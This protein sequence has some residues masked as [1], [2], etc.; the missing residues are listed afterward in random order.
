MKVTLFQCTNVNE[1]KETS[2]LPYPKFSSE[3]NSCDDLVKSVYCV[4]KHNGSLGLREGA[5]YVHLQ[6]VSIEHEIF[7]EKIMVKYKWTNMNKTKSVYSRSGRPGY[8][9]GKP[10]ITGTK[11]SN[12]ILMSNQ[13]EDWLTLPTAQEKGLCSN[14]SRTNLMFNVNTRTHCKLRFPRVSPISQQFCASLQDQVFYYD[15]FFLQAFI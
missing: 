3:N 11:K 8:I 9:T 4:L 15:S 6:N 10:I 13:A 12:V 1:C 5:C 14:K 2:S 7:T